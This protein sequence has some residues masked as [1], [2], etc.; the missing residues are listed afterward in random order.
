MGTEERPPYLRGDVVCADLNPV[1]GPRCDGFERAVGQGG[2]AA[3][4][5]KRCRKSRVCLS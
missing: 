3:L 5:W 2:Y 4:R 1:R